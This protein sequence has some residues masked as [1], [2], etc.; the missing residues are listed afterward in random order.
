MNDPYKRYQCTYC[1]FVYDEAVG[2]PESGIPPGTRWQ[3]IPDEWVCPDC[4][5]GKSSFEME[6]I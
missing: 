3:D 4:G 2:H 6:E 1:G 5:N